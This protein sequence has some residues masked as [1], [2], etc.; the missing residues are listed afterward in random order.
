MEARAGRTPTT[1]SA[2]DP[3]SIVDARIEG[4]V[5]H[6]AAYVLRPPGEWNHLRVV[7]R[8]YQV[9]HFLNGIQV[10]SIGMD[11]TRWAE[12]VAGTG[13]LSDPDL[14][15]MPLGRLAQ[16]DAGIDVWLRNVKVRPLLDPVTDPMTGEAP[17]VAVPL[18]NGTDLAGW[19]HRWWGIGE[20]RDL[21]TYDDEQ[22]LVCNG[23]RLAFLC[24][25][26]TYQ[27]FL[28]EFEQRWDPV[29]RQAGKASVLLFMQS[30][31]GLEGADGDTAGLPESLEVR[32]QFQDVGSIWLHHDFPL[33]PDRIRT[34][35]PVT[36]HIERADAVVG[37]WNRISIRSEDGRLTVYANDVLVN[38]VTGVGGKPGHIGFLCDV[39]QFDLRNVF[40]TPL[41]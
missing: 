28:L 33:D 40:L 37:E 16:L 13:W 29:T 9:D 18:F 24:T 21:W 25:R 23:G 35:G 31:E 39:T 27:D 22:N 11:S 6:E 30:T 26:G 15:R 38:D 3:D 32:L 41:D 8:G 34:R 4:G 1:L 7:A 20:P 14:G 19:V 17:V 10:L 12:L 2:D 36:T 5:L